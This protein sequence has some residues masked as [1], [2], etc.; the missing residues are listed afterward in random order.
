VGGER[1]GTAIERGQKKTGK[2]NAGNK[3]RCDSFREEYGYGVYK[4][5]AKERKRCENLHG[6]IGVKKII[7][8]R[9]VEPRNQSQAKIHN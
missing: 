1:V 9:G 6:Q 5:K 2:K 8:E 7:W 4:T 3:P